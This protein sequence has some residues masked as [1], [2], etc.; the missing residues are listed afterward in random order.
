MKIKRTY[1]ELV[2]EITRLKQYIARLERQL[3]GSKSD[4]IK[5]KEFLAGQPGLFDDFFKEALDEKATEVEAAAKKIDEDA[6]KRRAA[7]RKKPNRPA[8]Y[9]YAGLEE[10]TTLVMPEGVNADDCDVIGKDVTRILHREPA[11]L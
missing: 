4:R 7:S 11:K 5:A 6:A 2:A 9:Q 3:Y 8:K 1:N 10:R